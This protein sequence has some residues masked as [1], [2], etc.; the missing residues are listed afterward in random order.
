MTKI[1]VSK[2]NEV[3]LKIESE[4]HV[5]QELSD[6][7]SFDIEGAKYM[8]QYRRRYWDG[9]I[10][11]FST[12]TRELYVGLLDKLVSFCKRHGYEFEFT[13]NPTYDVVLLPG[14]YEIEAYYGWWNPDTNLAQNYQFEQSSVINNSQLIYV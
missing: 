13:N 14:E 1:I 3:F 9:K 6:H 11:L 2:K 5:Y 8:N 4:P 12:H 7:F 10:R